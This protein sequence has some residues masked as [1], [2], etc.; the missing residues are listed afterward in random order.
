MIDGLTERILEPVFEISLVSKNIR[1]QEMHQG[2]KLHNVI[3]QRSSC[4]QEASIC[5]ESKECLP[6]LR[7]EV[8]DVLSFIKY[9][10]VPL[11]PSE[12]K[13]VLNY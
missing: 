1:H 10:V 12:R 13:M 6:A 5:I 4:E 9:H 11:F 2:P 7:F 8:F 3:L